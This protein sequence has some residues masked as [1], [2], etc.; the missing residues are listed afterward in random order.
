MFVA[1]AKH[2][3]STAVSLLANERKTVPVI[4]SILMKLYLI[5]IAL[6]LTLRYSSG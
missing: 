6:Y 1:S 2:G 4:Q 5:L 3:L